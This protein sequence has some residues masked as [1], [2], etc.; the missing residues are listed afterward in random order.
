MQV[1]IEQ[2]YLSLANL[3]ILSPE[4]SIRLVSTKNTDSA[5]A[6]LCVVAVKVH[7]CNYWLQLLFLIFRVCIEELGVCGSPASC[8]GTGQT[9]GMGLAV[10]LQL[11]RCP[12]LYL[13]RNTVGCCSW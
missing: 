9:L 11:Q 2:N 10:Y 5:R 1:Y 3:P 13:L 7:F 8:F 6:N 4:S 12:I